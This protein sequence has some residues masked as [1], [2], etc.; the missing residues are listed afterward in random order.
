MVSK[1]VVDVI[2]EL[3]VCLR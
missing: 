2:Y 1:Y 3:I